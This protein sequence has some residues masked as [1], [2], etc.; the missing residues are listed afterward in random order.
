MPYSTQTCSVF[1][2]TLHQE[3]KTRYIYTFIRVGVDRSNFDSE[4][5]QNIRFDSGSA[6]RRFATELDFSSIFLLI[7]SLIHKS[8]IA[9]SLCHINAAKFLS[10]AH[11][12]RFFCPYV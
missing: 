12:L 9:D 11:I 6:L 4:R 10:G 7:L 5:R 8:A 2:T 1:L 3:H